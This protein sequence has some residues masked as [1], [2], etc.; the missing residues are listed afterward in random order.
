M[1]KELTWKMAMTML[2]T[3]KT[4]MKLFIIPFDR[5]F[6]LKLFDNCLVTLGYVQKV[7]KKMSRNLEFG[8]KAKKN[9]LESEKN[10]LENL[11]VC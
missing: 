6:G 1:E 3:K 10:Q 11:K 7:K 2:K 9:V 4:L 5:K 8:V